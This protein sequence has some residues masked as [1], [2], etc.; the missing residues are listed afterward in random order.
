M[1]QRASST[2]RPPAG[3][4]V[5][6][7]MDGNGR[8]ALRR[9]LS[10]SAGHREGAKAVRRI[11]EAAPDAGVG[12][13]S[14]FAF[15]A[16]NWRRPAMEVAWLM[17]LFREHLHLETARCVANGVRLEV[18]GRRDRLGLDLLRAIEAAEVATSGGSRLL[19]RIAVDY[20]GRDAILRAAQCLRPGAASRDAFGRL[21]AIVDHGSPVPELDLLIRTGGERRLS[22]FL[23]WEAAY[24]EL[25]FVPIM[26]P[27]FGAE[28]LRAAVRDFA[29][30]ERRFGGIPDQAVG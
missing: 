1:G 19:L 15:S 16:D 20:S 21:V 29:S 14:L 25:Y 28:D 10:R 22:D 6:I 27:D 18:I 3:L 26:W 11:V 12:V 9:G 23:L 8:W 7:I 30:R 24:A 13:L 5:G 4:H 2:V 17:R